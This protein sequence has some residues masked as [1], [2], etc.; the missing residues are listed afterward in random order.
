M[1]LDAPSGPWPPGPGGVRET[2]AFPP[3]TV[4]R[5]HRR[6]STSLQA[7]NRPSP[8]LLAAG[9]WGRT[10]CAFSSGPKPGSG[11]ACTRRPTSAPTH[12]R[13]VILQ[14]R[15]D[16]Q[17]TPIHPIRCPKR[18]DDQEERHFTPVVHASHHFGLDCGRGA[19]DFTCKYLNLPLASTGWR[20][21]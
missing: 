9:A 19:A 12:R 18:P 15:D 5:G 1:S 17:H 3:D 11:F 13:K 20:W 16:P 21:T 7:G 6:V 2:Q 8:T 4:H 10:R 14:A